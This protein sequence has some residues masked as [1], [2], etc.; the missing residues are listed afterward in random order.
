MSSWVLNVAENEGSTTSLAVS[1][2]WEAQAWTRHSRCFSP[3]VSKEE[4]SQEEL[5]AF[6]LL[7]YTGHFLLLAFLTSPFYKACVHPLPH[8]CRQVS[9]VHMTQHPLF[10]DPIHYF[11]IWWWVFISLLITHN[12]VHHRFGS[13]LLE[14]TLFPH[15]VRWIVSLVSSLPFSEG[16]S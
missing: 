12:L 9:L 13:S 5:H 16:V 11:L 3:V 2:H 8:C 7:S 14:K 10:A 1:L 4:R 6:L 15:V